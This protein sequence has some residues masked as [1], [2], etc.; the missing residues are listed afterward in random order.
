MDKNNFRLLR[1]YV[2]L[3]SNKNIRQCSEMQYKY[4]FQKKEHTPDDYE[5][6]Y[7]CLLVCVEIFS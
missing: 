3:T 2:I 6:L 5:K 4:F 1:N 7:K